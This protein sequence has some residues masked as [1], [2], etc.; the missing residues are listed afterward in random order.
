MVYPSQTLS[1][2]G[3]T[4]P[5]A[6][7]ASGLPTGLSLNAQAGVISGTP[8]QSGPFN[9]LLQVTD[10][11]GASAPKSITLTIS[12]PLAIVTPSLP[13]GTLNSVYPPV[14]LT[15]TGGTPPYTWSASG[16]PTGLA[17]NPQTGVISGTPTQSGQFSVGVSVNDSA[18]ASTS[19][20]FPLNF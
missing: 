10:L 18:G 5:Y 7:S 20:T 17:V 6:W 11:A 1:A 2:T 8:T 3:G 14:T 9:V 19:M 13:N 4:P 16:L 15:P 12:G